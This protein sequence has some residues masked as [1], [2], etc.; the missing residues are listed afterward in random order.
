MSDQKPLSVEHET[1]AGEERMEE[2][3]PLAAAAEPGVE[4]CPNCGAEMPEVYCGRCGQKGGTLNLP[5]RELVA[6]YL[7][8]AFRLEGQLLHTLLLLVTK[9]GVVTA[10]YLAGRRA[11][12]TSPVRLYIGASLVFFGL[13][14]LTQSV[15]SSYYQ[16]TEL[17][18]EDLA[19]TTPRIFFFTLPLFAL[20]L[21]LAYLRSGRPLVHHV[22][23]AL[24]LGATGMLLFLALLLVSKA[25]KLV[26][27]VQDAAPFEVGWIYLAGPIVFAG[28]QFVGMHVV[29]PEGPFRT[30]L[31]FWL[32]ILL[33]WPLA[34]TI[35]AILSRLF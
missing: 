9:P 30:V 29:Y 16:T 28:Y 13:V 1:R 27:G 35:G 26:W 12:Y 7:Q 6:E 17:L 4:T 34:L 23:F 33:V 14:L 11:R 10:D 15:D 21:K 25:Y 19:R 18:H 8:E 24:H 22:I 2:L 31:K 5:I 20:G 32:L 3:S